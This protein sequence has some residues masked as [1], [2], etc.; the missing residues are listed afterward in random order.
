MVRK[1]SKERDGQKGMARKAW[2]DVVSG[3]CKNYYDDI[4]ECRLETVGKINTRNDDQYIKINEV[5][6][7]L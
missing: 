3:I 6:H 1:A 2:K 5:T 7:D 4:K